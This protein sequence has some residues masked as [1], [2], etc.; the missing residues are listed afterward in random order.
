MGRSEKGEGMGRS[1]M[2]EGMGRSTGRTT[3][4]VPQSPEPFTAKQFREHFLVKGK[5]L[6]KQLKNIQLKPRTREATMI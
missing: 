4:E 2:E 3:R 5:E 1:D 6:L